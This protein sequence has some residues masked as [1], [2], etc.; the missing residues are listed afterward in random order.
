MSSDMIIL[1]TRHDIQRFRE[2]TAS[3]AICEYDLTE[4][5]SNVIV[6]LEYR[7]QYATRIMDFCRLYMTFGA[8]DV[9]T[10]TNDGQ[11]ISKAWFNLAHSISGL[12][13]R[14][15]LWGED[16]HAPYYY[17]QLNAGD[18]VLKTYPP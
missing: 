5:L 11:I 18:M 8:N 4:V 3:M 14:I 6:A 9:T 13:D 15:G 7:D 1:P 16:G 10:N 12:Y 2:E 17:H